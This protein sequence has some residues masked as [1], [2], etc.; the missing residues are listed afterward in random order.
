[1]NRDTSK[2]HYGN[3]TIEVGESLPDEYLRN[4]CIGVCFCRK[5]GNEPASFSCSHG[6][7]SRIFA[8]YAPP[9]RDGNRIECIVQRPLD[10]CCD[11]DTVC[12]PELEKLE[13]CEYAGEIYREGER[14]DLM[15]VCT[16]KCAC[17]KGFNN[18]KT[19]DENP[20]CK[21]YNCKLAIRNSIEF[22]QGCIPVFDKR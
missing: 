16:H 10:E 14:I 7:C 22:A 17:G 21:R 20:Y 13:T 12:S 5:S 8:P 19:F 3:H 15:G 4:S 2:C 9:D 6:D 11:S 18:Y 1:M